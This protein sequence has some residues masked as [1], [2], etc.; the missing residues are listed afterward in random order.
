MVCG[1][2]CD[3]TLFNHV[4]LTPEDDVIALASF[5][6]QILSDTAPPALK[7][8]CAAYK[9]GSCSIYPDRPHACRQFRCALL[10]RFEAEKVSQGDALKIIREAAIL[11]DELREGMGAVFG[12]S[13]GTL[14]QFSTRLKDRWNDA[15]SVEAKDRV[16][17]LFEKFA[18]LWLC[19]NKHFRKQWQR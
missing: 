18:A 10:R 7:Q 13:D 5:G 1:L 4:D 14:D 6:L 9:N 11:R 3:G 8:C 16:F 2:C 15:T 12:D 19:V 17:E